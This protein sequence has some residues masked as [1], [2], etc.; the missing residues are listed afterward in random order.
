MALGQDHRHCKICGRVCPVGA[1]TCS[2]QCA[3]TRDERLRSLWFWTGIM[4]AMIVFLAAV[5][6]ISYI[7]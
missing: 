4:Y 7:R 6:V 2:A 1:D 5:L 3:T